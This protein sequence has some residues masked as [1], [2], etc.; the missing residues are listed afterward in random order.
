[1][2]E[3]LGA[4]RPRAIVTVTHVLATF[5]GGLLVAGALVWARFV[6]RATRGARPD[7]PASGSALPSSSATRGT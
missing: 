2:T 6:A 5:G 3:S 1:M 4:R 7:D